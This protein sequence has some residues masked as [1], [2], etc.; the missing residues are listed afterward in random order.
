MNLYPA[1]SAPTS[2]LMEIL[3]Q[4]PA[5]PAGYDA[6]ANSGW[7]GANKLYTALLPTLDAKQAELAAAVL[8]ELRERESAR[9]LAA[10]AP[11]VEAAPAHEAKYIAQAA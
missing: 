6:L 2:K 4:L 5:A 8:D 7:L 9:L 10:L 3:T 11:I 1:T